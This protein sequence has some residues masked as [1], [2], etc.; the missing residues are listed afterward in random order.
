MHKRAKVPSRVIAYTFLL[1]S[2][3][4]HAS[5]T[6]EAAPILLGALAL[7]VVLLPGIKYLTVRRLFALE[8]RGVGYFYL[9]GVGELLAALLVV[10]LDGGVM[11]AA[12][13]LGALG[14]NLLYFA[15]SGLR[16]G[17]GPAVKW[18][19]LTLMT[20][21]FLFLIMMSIAATAST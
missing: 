6:A 10:D 13:L 4:L 20:P 21:M 16:R 7:A 18:V 19:V 5:V 14:I 1:L 17:W 2:H 8:G 12:Y 9:V 11:V 15:G 3:P